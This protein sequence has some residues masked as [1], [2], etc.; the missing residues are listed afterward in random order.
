MALTRVISCLLYDD[1]S[2]LST[3]EE[4]SLANSNYVLK[5]MGDDDE[6]PM[7]DWKNYTLCVRDKNESYVSA[8]LELMKA[9]LQ[10]AFIAV[11]PM[12]RL[13]EALVLFQYAATGGFQE[14]LK[15]EWPFLCHLQRN[16]RGRAESQTSRSSATERTLQ[17]IESINQYDLELYKLVNDLFE[18][19]LRIFQ[20]ERPG[21][22]ESKVSAMEDCSLLPKL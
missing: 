1:E 14:S 16:A 11:A 6:C 9:N 5:Y 18:E 20:A 3:I 10:R 21:V 19:Q 17:Y 7:V 13:K 2:R 8:A 4:Y 22:L 12:E 15:N